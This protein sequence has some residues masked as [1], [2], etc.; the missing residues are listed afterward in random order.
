MK[1][2]EK[3][4]SFTEVDI[5]PPKLLNET[6]WNLRSNDHKDLHHFDVRK[7]LLRSR[8]ISNT[9]KLKTNM[10]SQNQIVE[11]CF[12]FGQEVSS[13]FLPGPPEPSGR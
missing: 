1:G 7:D 9:Q 13:D 6:D 8:F 4:L 2:E 10:K 5:R 3:V 11:K 12:I